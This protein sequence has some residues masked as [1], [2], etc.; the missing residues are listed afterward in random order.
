MARKKDFEN[1]FRDTQAACGDIHREAYS[2]LA[3]QMNRY[4]AE[5]AVKSYLNPE[6]LALS[7]YED[8]W[9]E[10]SL[11]LPQELEKRLVDV[12]T[13][14]TEEQERKVQELLD[15]Y[16]LRARETYLHGFET[17]MVGRR[18]LK[19]APGKSFFNAVD[20]KLNSCRT[21]A[22]EALTR[23]IKTRNAQERMRRR[24]SKLNNVIAFAIGA[25]ASLVVQWAWTA[26]FASK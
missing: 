13:G 15:G 3:R 9:R 1:V 17:R 26:T 19:S 8:H 25:A 20:S 18:K 23:A 12:L 10:L 14:F 21:R 6:G 24:K 16:F 5:V 7:I 11:A 22:Q 4:A 2:R